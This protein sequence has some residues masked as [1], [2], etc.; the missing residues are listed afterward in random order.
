MIRTLLLL[1]FFTCLEAHG[2]GNI[3]QESGE[4]VGEGVSKKSRGM[5]C[6][7]ENKLGFTSIIKPMTLL[8]SFALYKWPTMSASMAFLI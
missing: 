7:G 1:F 2:Q 6:H 8:F 5:D 3:D 4:E